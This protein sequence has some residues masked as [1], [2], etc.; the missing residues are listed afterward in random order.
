MWLCA[1]SV[2]AF[3]AN[4]TALDSAGFLAG[5][6]T[7]AVLPAL[8]PLATAPVATSLLLLATEVP[9]DANLSGDTASAPARLLVRKTAVAVLATYG[10]AGRTALDRLLCDLVTATFF[11]R[12]A[13][14]PVYTA[15]HPR[16]GTADMVAQVVGANMVGWTAL[17]IDA[18]V[19][20]L[21]TN[22][23]ATLLLEPATFS[24][25]TH[26]AGDTAN[27][28]ATSTGLGA[29]TGTPKLVF[30]TFKA[31]VATNRLRV[32]VTTALLR[33]FAEYTK[34]IATF[35]GRIDAP[36]IARLPAT[37]LIGCAIGNP[38]RV[39]VQL[40]AGIGGP[41]YSQQAC[42]D[43]DEFLHGGVPCN[44]FL[45]WTETELPYDFFFNF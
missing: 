34:I 7:M 14:G 26:L 36:G 29:T 39:V 40:Q 8:L 2:V 13:L 9:L 19:P 17:A 28:F 32:I 6:A 24:V 38:A 5:D 18:Y 15:T 37:F 4:G 35:I 1:L 43:R 31:V 33:R 45:F 22:A 20:G 44:L 11:G 10:G 23:M 12:T 41:N 27:T 42:E 16:L 21:A 30:A 3:V 25:A